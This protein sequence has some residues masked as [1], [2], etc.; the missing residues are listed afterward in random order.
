MAVYV[1][2]CNTCGAKFEYSQ[3]MSEEPLKLCPPEVCTCSEKGKGEVSR[4]ITGA[5]LMFKGDGFYINDYARK[6]QS[7]SAE[8]CSTGSCAPCS[9][10]L[11]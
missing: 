9:A 5:G 2:K 4:V 3:K 7:S 1:Y 8:S 10:S 11:N 6:S